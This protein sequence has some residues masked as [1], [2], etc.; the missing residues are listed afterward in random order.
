M[1]TRSEGR[2]AGFTLIELLVVIAIIAI[3]VAL[4]LPALGRVKAQAKTTACLNNQKQLCLAWLM[5][6][7]DNGQWLPPKT[8][9]LGPATPGGPSWVLGWLENNP[10]FS[11]PDNTNLLHLQNSLLAPYLASTAP[12]W[13]CPSD[14]S[15]SLIYG[16]RLPRVRS[17]SMNGFIDSTPNRRD[18]LR[19]RI[20]RRSN[21]IP[22]PSELFV[23]IDER[24]DTIEDGFFVVDTYLEPP[25]H[26]PE[27]IELPDTSHNLTGALLAK[28]Y[29]KNDVAKIWGGNW[30]RIM[31][32]VWG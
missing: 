14:P 18:L 31:R 22:V 20:F 1:H 4:L 5:Y 10:D 2:R 23:T 3:L 7:D 9:Y 13:R 26:Y 24:E 17:Y 6:G 27:G 11:W 16:Q 15:S 32:Q 30:L 28:G 29:K 8:F 21:D 12:L 25:W 19:W